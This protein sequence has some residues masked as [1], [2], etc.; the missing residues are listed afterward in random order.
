[1]QNVSDPNASERL[2]RWLDRREQIRLAK[3]WCEARE[4]LRRPVQTVAIDVEQDEALERSLSGAVEEEAGADTCLQVIKRE[5]GALEVE[6]PPRW[7]SPSQ[8]VR[9]PVHEQVVDR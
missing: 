2:K 7:A 4:P 5:I 3:D 8:M 6:Q 9:Q 1:M